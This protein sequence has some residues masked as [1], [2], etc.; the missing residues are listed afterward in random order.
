VRVLLVDDGETTRGLLRSV[1]EE[2]GHIIEE[3]GDGVEALEKMHVSTFDAVVSDILLPRMD[4]YRLCDE[5]RR[6]DAFSGV[7]FVF[8]TATYTSPDDEGF[9]RGLGADAYL[10]KPVSP[11][12]ML[13]TLASLALVPPAHRDAARALDAP[14]ATK[15]YN[16][17][18]VRRLEEK[19]ASLEAAQSALV[20]ANAEL[21][22]AEA[23]NRLLLES[24]D[25]AIFGIDG[26]G[27]FDFCNAACVSTLGFASPAALMGKDAHATLHPAGARG[28][29]FCRPEECGFLRVFRD[30]GPRGVNDDVFGRKNGERF[31]V[32][33][34]CSPIRRNGER[35]GAVVFF[36]D[37]GDRRRA[38]LAMRESEERYRSLFENM[39]NGF[40]YQRVIFEGDRAV[41]T[42]CLAVNGAFETLTGLT[43]VVGK[44]TT[45]FIPGIAER[46]PGLFEAYGRV[47]RGGG[48]ERL[49]LRVE[50]LSAWY[51]ISM[52]S[53]GP[54]HVV[55]IFDVITSRKEAEERL[56]SSETRYRNIVEQ[57]SA[58]IT[59][60]DLEGRMLSINRQAAATL[61]RDRAT[62]GD[63]NVRDLLAPEFAETFDDYLAVMRRDGHASGLMVVVTTAGARRVLEYHNVLRTD[64]GGSQ[65]LVHGV[66]LD[67]T[68]RIDAERAMRISEHRIVAL[69]ENAGDA[70]FVTNTQG[71]IV[72]VNRAAERLIGRP[73]KEIVNASIGDFVEPE[74]R[75]A[76]ERAFAETVQGGAISG[77]EALA[78]RR[79]GAS[80]PIEVSAS[81]VS[82][83][84]AQLVHAIVRDVSERKRLEDQLRQA[85]KMEAVGRLAAGLA[86]DFNNLLM[87]VQS[88]TDVLPLHAAN[89]VAQER[90]FE[91]L[92]TAARSGAALTGQLLAFSRP[93]VPRTERLDVG[94]V[95]SGLAPM[96][97]RLIGANIEFVIDAA[98]GAG[99][100][101]MDRGQ[102]EQ[103][104]V[105]LVVNASDAMASGGRLSITV[106]AKR[107]TAAE[108]TAQGGLPAGEYSVIAVSDTGGGMAPV[109]RERIFEPFF[110]TKEIG[111]GTGL[112]LATVYGIVKGCGGDIGVESELG[113]GTVFRIYLP[114]FETARRVT[115]PASLTPGGT[116]IDRTVLVVEGEAAV[117][118][119]IGTY[120]EEEGFLVFSASSSA[121]A[122]ERLAGE[123]EPIPVVVTAIS[124]PGGS[125]FDVANAARSRDRSTRVILTSGTAIG[126]EIAD[127]IA[128]EGSEFLARP[129]ELSVL[130]GRI[131][132]S[133]ARDRA[134]S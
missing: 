126:A 119:M 65:P 3:A 129:F 121:E 98:P 63:L 133:F 108:G 73:R 6:V 50:A 131:G 112:G 34:R 61:G 1:L 67:V 49:E 92:R 109:V 94:A 74:G 78:R 5:V 76:V 110:T 99:V 115:R 15:Q 9:G 75:A 102:L 36:S 85:Q 60:H 132:E 53:P 22:A 134:A 71:V 124:I 80:V 38:E 26:E 55:A 51:A 33:Y 69:M 100:I 127:R 88:V 52:Y 64:E 7:H 24:A 16:A 103:V 56:Q 2:A 101:R 20:A 122:L 81:L 107:L 58:W 97:E 106:G 82:V 120:L 72:Q 84:G 62:I 11:R 39:L 90:D 8:H 116:R 117:R 91:S 47:A 45:E 66:A 77:F 95:I 118:E 43:D 125:G 123:R 21:S 54:D 83:G 104:L 113:R 27:R 29:A 17:R 19:S 25:D 28:D 40:A 18:L 30:P 96:M 59:T 10:R 79:G 86:H 46:D 70:I 68:E 93:K 114:R 14:D 111:R 41:D 12:M 37:S 130:A 4:G 32:E 57:T 105:N 42:L 48:P 31:P 35:A 23:R 44:R 89:P 13:D 128:A 87:I